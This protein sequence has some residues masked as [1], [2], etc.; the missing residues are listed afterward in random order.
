MGR[1][2]GVAASEALFR[3]HLAASPARRRFNR[4]FYYVLQ[5]LGF[6]WVAA[7]LW[8]LF[9]HGN[10]DPTAFAYTGA[11]GLFGMSFVLV[12]AQGHVLLR[13]VEGAEEALRKAEARRPE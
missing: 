7:G 12:G 2:A 11:A 8:L 3:H 4:V 1:A 10:G 9:T 5:G 13:V 6:L